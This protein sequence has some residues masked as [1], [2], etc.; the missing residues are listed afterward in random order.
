VG[1]QQYDMM[2]LIL[3]HLPNEIAEL[4]GQHVRLE[5]LAGSY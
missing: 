2:E 3:D 4:A 1:F 5:D